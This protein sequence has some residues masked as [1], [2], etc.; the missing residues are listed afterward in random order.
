MESVTLLKRLIDEGAA[1]A[2]AYSIDLVYRDLYNLLFDT[3]RRTSENLSSMLQDFLNGKSIEI[4]SQNGELCRLGRERNI[5]LPTHYTILQIV[6]L[7][8][9]RHRERNHE[10]LE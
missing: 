8:E 9:T 2:D 1:V 3:C 7:L 10:W 4:D 5:N 6:K